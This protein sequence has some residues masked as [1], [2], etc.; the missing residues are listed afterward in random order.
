MSS[1]PPVVN[2]EVMRDLV[3]ATI[4]KLSLG[5]SNK[6]NFKNILPLALSSNVAFWNVM[7]LTQN[8]TL[9]N[10]DDSGTEIYFKNTNAFKYNASNIGN[11]SLVSHVL[12]NPVVALPVPAWYILILK[13]N[14]FPVTLEVYDASNDLINDFDYILAN[15]P[16]KGVNLFDYSPEMDQVL[17]RHPKLEN[18]HLTIIAPMP[19]PSVKILTVSL[20]DYWEEEL[21]MLSPKTTHLT[22]EFERNTL[23]NS[24]FDPLIGF[25]QHDLEYLNVLMTYNQNTEVETFM[26]Y[27]A[28]FLTDICLPI[29]KQAVNRKAKDFRL[30]LTY[31]VE[32]MEVPLITADQITEIDDMFSKCSFHRVEKQGEKTDEDV[33][34]VVFAFSPREKSVCTC[35]IKANAERRVHNVM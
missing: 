16:V 28:T 2:I 14:Q 7:R 12:A 33:P 32:V 10:T 30:N 11:S 20:G 22:I 27:L 5:D 26:S 13:E 31:K 8:A 3:E 29:M 23:Y 34:E 1:S 17:R 6:R 19:M 15:V 21:L 25:F 9:G 18:I 35:F 24:S 4:H